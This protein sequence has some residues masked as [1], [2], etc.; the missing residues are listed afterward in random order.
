MKKL[1]LAAAMMV[2]SLAASAQVYVGGSLGFQSIKP[3]DG[4]ETSTTF[5]IMPEIGYNL[6]DNWAVGI[7]LGYTSSNADSDFEKTDFTKAI[8]NLNPYARYT[9]AKTGI[10]SFFVDGGLPS[11][12]IQ[13]MPKVWF[14]ELEYAPVSNWLY[15]KKLT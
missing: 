3:Y 6:D 15:L 2:A 4:A 7:Q 11:T 9:F 8:I 13:P 12:S 5:S 1:F 14:G 10:A